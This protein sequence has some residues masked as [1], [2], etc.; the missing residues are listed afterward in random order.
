MSN[1][2][3]LTE[4]SENTSQDDL[5]IV[6][7]VKKRKAASRKKSKSKSRSGSKK[8]KSVKPLKLDNSEK[9]NQ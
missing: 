8:K 4:V 7:G 2:A 3:L 5:S 1:N 9:M 6:G